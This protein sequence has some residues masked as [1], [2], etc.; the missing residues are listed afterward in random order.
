MKA[1]DEMEKMKNERNGFEHFY[2]DSQSSIPESGV[3]VGGR[4]GGGRVRP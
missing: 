1:A 3:G 2:F 4:G